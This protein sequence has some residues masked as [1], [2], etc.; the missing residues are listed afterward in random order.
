MQQSSLLALYQFCN[1]QRSQYSGTALVHP[2]ECVDDI[3]MVLH[4]KRSRIR[5]A[6]ACVLQGRGISGARMRTLQK[7]RCQP[8]R[9]L[10]A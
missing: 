7:L 8:F 1:P 9:T 3:F 5:R 6:S 4:L 10:T 2:L